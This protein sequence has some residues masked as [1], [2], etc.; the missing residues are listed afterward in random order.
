[1]TKDVLKYLQPNAA[2]PI[3]METTSMLVNALKDA[4]AKQKPV[5]WIH[6]DPEKPKVRFLEWKE[7]EQGYR[8][9]WIKKPL[10]AHPP[11]RTEQEP[12]ALD[13][14]TMELAESVGLIGPASRTHDLHAA[15][16]RFH[17]LICVN[18]TIKAAQMAADAIREATPPTQPE[19]RT[20]QNFCSRCGKRTPDLI[21]IHTC[22]P[23]K[24]NT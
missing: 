21:T 14:A 17:D 20:E 1:M 5:A 11:Q 24:E 19:Q 8:G 12:V 6:I 7:N 2:I 23:P 13:Q 15:I 22:T 3:D 16:Q 9:K 4:Y 10:Y 18:A